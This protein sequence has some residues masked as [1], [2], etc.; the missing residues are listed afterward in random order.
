MRGVGAPNS[1]CGP[2]RLRPISPAAAPVCR[3]PCV[4]GGQGSSACT[5]PK[6]LQ[7]KHTPRPSPPLRRHSAPLPPTPAHPAHP[8]PPTPP[9]SPPPPAAYPAL[10]GKKISESAYNDVPLYDA[11]SNSYVGVTT[12]TSVKLNLPWK[13]EI[14]QGKGATKIGTRVTA[15]SIGIAPD[16]YN[17]VKVRADAQTRTKWA[18]SKAYAT[19]YG[20]NGGGGNVFVYA[21]ARATQKPGLPW[22]VASSN[23]DAV[24][25]SGGATYSDAGVATVLSSSR[26]TGGTGITLAS[27]KG[28]AESANE[29]YVNIDARSN[30]AKWYASPGFAMTGAEAIARGGHAGIFSDIRE[31]VDKGIALGGLINIAKSNGAQSNFFYLLPAGQ[32]GAI[33]GNGWN[34]IVYTQ[35]KNQPRVDVGLGAAGTINIG[36]A[37]AGKVCARRMHQHAL[38]EPRQHRSHAET[39]RAM[40]SHAQPCSHAAMQPSRPPGTLN[41]QPAETPLP[42]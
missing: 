9:P 23:S 4:G 41:P 36:S 12:D 26:A 30:S 37:A 2:R 33:N 35:T 18:P 22:T 6:D 16:V 39:C 38:A 25:I 32:G 28:Y 20:E 21:N 42:C 19:A 29:A 14:I 11:P 27:A 10:A 7:P 8:L 5:H 13:E 31:R 15:Q 1:S 24:A 40:Q 34:N 17:A 3:G